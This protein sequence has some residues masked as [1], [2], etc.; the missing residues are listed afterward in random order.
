PQVPDPALRQW[1][2]ERTGP[3]S[4]NGVVGAIIKRSRPAL[5][6]PDLFLFGLVGN[7][8]GYYPGYSRDLEAD[9]RHFTWGVLKAHTH[10]T[11]GEVRLSSADPR[12]R[13]AIGFHYFE[14]GGDEDL[15][16]VVEGVVTVRRLMATLGDAV[17]REVVPGPEV[18]TRADIAR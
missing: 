18:R 13:P 17:K 8:R 4:T 9:H 1:W 10:N 3:Y 15:E 2:F 16:A 14:Q 6:L 5:P 11:A 7:F 12:D